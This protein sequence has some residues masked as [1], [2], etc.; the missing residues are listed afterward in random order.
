M[1]SDMPRQPA[2][3]QAVESVLSRRGTAAV[4][5]WAQSLWPIRRVEQCH[6]DVAVASMLVGLRKRNAITALI[7]WGL[8]AAQ[9]GLYNTNTM[10][11][12]PT[13]A[14]G[15]LLVALWDLE[16]HIN[17][18]WLEAD[19]RWMPQGW[20]QYQ[21]PS[22]NLPGQREEQ[23]LR[24]VLGLL[25]PPSTHTLLLQLGFQ[26]RG[27]EYGTCCNC[28]FRLYFDYRGCEQCSSLVGVSWL[29][30]PEK[31]A[32]RTATEPWQGGPYPLQP[33]HSRGC[34]CILPTR[35][36][37]AFSFTR[38]QA[39]AAPPLLAA[40]TITDLLSVPALHKVLRWWVK[41]NE[42]HPPSHSHHI[43]QKP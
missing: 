32:S 18:V 26:Q 23:S 3:V 21:D 20:A 14:T 13:A 11:W 5:S 12:N 27:S 9:W 39:S 19:L 30:L 25:P 35:L 1:A 42:T 34:S 7:Q 24:P 36:A 15:Q 10:C 29:W 41:G 43:C 28:G 17:T 40:P 2:S 37:L 16:W 4:W 8:A 6:A 22:Q 31:A 38:T 33:V